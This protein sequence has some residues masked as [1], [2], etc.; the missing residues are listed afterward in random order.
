MQTLKNLKAN[1]KAQETSL[2]KTQE[3]FPELIQ[4][5]LPELRKVL[6]AG[7]VERWARTAISTYRL[8][9][10]LS[11]CDPRSVM[12]A[13]FQVAQLGLEINPALGEAYL[14]PFKDKCQVIPGYLGLMKLARNSG[15]VADIYGHEVREKDSFRMKLG[16]ERKLEH[17]P[18]CL[19]GGFPAPEEERGA[20]VG[21]YAV[22]V[23]RSGV[24][25]FAAM[26]RKEVER[27]RNLSPGY[28]VAK[29]LGKESV[30]DTDFVAMGLKTVIRR[31]CKFLPKSTELATA[32]ALDNLAENGQQNLEL[33][34]VLEGEY[35]PVPVEAIDD[36]ETASSTT[37][38][39]D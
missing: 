8:S 38:T 21:F 10:S 39:P 35:V 3:T 2:P 37:T 33:D 22:A 18:L 30:W 17:T 23:L 34:G 36:K 1:L 28:Q 4:K 27:V 25:T 15:F 32:L 20:V 5:Y 9:G 14:V 29:R 11:K 13:V 24:S 6:P 12:A 7:V 16:L 31:L 19:E 26:S